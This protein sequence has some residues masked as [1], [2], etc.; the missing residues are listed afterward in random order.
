MSGPALRAAVPDDGALLAEVHAEAF[1]RPWSAGDLAALLRD[2][3][4]LGLGAFE[5]ERLQ[6]FVLLR[7]V[8]EEAEVL[9]LAVR[10]SSRR[11]GLARGLLDAAS[12]LV[13][14]AGA[15]TLFLEVAADNAAAL[16][17]YRQAGFVEAG[18]RRGYYARENAPSIDAQVM[19]RRLNT[20]PD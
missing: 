8:S 10:P 13:A 3:G 5:A 18:L 19:R 15:A 20:G 12:V 16:A 4:A 9:T 7:R 2:P 17:L 14:Q 11:R 1:P 6:G